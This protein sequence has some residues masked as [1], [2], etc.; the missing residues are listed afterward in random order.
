MLYPTSALVRCLCSKSH[1]MQVGDKK[2]C[3]CGVVLALKIDSR[4]NAVPTARI[5]ANSMAEW[6]KD[7]HPVKY[8]SPMVT[9][10]RD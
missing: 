7:G 4:G 9:G 10:Y 8:S 6:I 3:T 2:S 5:D 1:V